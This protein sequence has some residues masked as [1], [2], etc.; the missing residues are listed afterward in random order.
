MAANKNTVEVAEQKVIVESVDLT[1]KQ[2]ATTPSVVEESSASLSEAEIAALI[3]AQQKAKLEIAVL[4][5]Q[6]KAEKLKNDNSQKSQQQQQNKFVQLSSVN[7]ALEDKVSSLDNQVNIQ[8]SYLAES[9]KREKALADTL[10]KQRLQYSN[11]LNS[12]IKQIKSEIEQQPDLLK[13]N[14]TPQANDA[15]SDAEFV[16]VAI[17]ENPIQTDVVDANEEQA[18][19]EEHFSGAVEFGFNF[20]QDNQLTKSVE[21]RLILDYNVIDKYNLN[22]DVQFEYEN[23]DG[24]DTENEWRWQLQA[25]Y[26]LNPLD[27]AFIRSDIQRSEFSSY[28]IEDTYTVGYGHIFFNENH[29]KFNVEVGPGYK[30]AIPNDG[31]DEVSFNEFIL[32]TRLN[33]E[34]IVTENLQ[35]TTEGIL[36]LGRENSVYEVELRAQNRIYQQLYLIFDVNYKYNQNVP[37]DSENGEI[38]TGL[39]LQYAF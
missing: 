20:E 22:S 34:R 6:L 19:E 5:E 38:S 25:N 2:V 24:E 33:Y 29:H 3:E 13:T 27:T 15:I 32:R 26:N 36:E 9:L 17:S 14:K 7:E 21:G 8:E 35:L 4:K 37:E 16:E 30:V 12:P 39:N 11:L 1:P 18:I 28:Q 10:K 31:E 23:E